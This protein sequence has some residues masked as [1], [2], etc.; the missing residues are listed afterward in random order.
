MGVNLVLRFST[1]YAR[2]TSVMHKRN[3]IDL[4]RTLARIFISPFK[5][6]LFLQ[7]LGCGE[8]YLAKKCL[9]RA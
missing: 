7:K 9:N 1:L 4:A 8:T 3:E 2:Y 5:Y 6:D